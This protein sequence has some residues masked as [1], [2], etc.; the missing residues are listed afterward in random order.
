[1]RERLIKK[2]RFHEMFNKIATSPARQIKKN[3]QMKIEREVK[4]LYRPGLS[5]IWAN[6]ASETTV[7]ICLGGRNTEW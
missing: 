5:L 2:I 4:S 3:K 6:Y 7:L 1:M